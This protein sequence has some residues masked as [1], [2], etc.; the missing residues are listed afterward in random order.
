MLK[1]LHKAQKQKNHPT[2]RDGFGFVLLKDG[3]TKLG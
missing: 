2:L 1:D 3:T